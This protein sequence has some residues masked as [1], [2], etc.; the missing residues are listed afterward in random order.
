MK[1]PL[2]VTHKKQTASFR[3]VGWMLAIAPLWLAPH[4]AAPQGVP[5]S[6]SHAFGSSGSGNN[7]S[8]AIRV[9]PDQNLY[10]IGQFSSTA[11][12]GGTTITSAGGSDIFVAKYNPSGSLLLITQAGGSSD[13]IGQGIDVDENANVYVTGSFHGD[14]TFYSANPNDTKIEVVS[15]ENSEQIFLAKYNQSGT[16]Q[17][18]QTGAIFFPQFLNRGQAV[19]VNSATGTVYLAAVNQ[20]S[21]TF[22]SA[23]GKIHVVDGANEWHMVLAR[24]DTN[25]NFQWAQTN[26]ANPNSIPYAVA[27]DAQGNAYVTGWLENSTTFSSANGH[28]ITAVGFSPGQSDQNFPD[29]AF[30]AKYDKNG[31]VKWVNHIGGYKAIPSAL[32][33][34]PSGEVS[35]VGFIGNI[36]NGT[37]GEA[38]TTATSQPPGTNVSLGGGT[39]TNPYNLDEVIATYSGSGVLQRVLRRGGSGDERATGVAYDSRSNLYVTGLAEVSGHPNLF[40]DEYSSSNLLWHATATNAGIWTGQQPAIMPAMA[41]DAAGSAFVTGAYAGAAQFGDIT[42]NGTG[43]S[44]AFIA[45]LNTAFANQM[46]DLLLRPTA[47]PLPV[48]QGDLLTYTFPV[49]NLGPNVAYHEVLN[50]QVP[51]GTTFDYVRISGTPGLGTCTTPPYGGTGQIICHENGSMAPNTTW[52]VRLTVKVTAPSGTV[53]TENAATMADTPDPNMANNTATVSTTVQREA[54]KTDRGLFREDKENRRG[55]CTKSRILPVGRTEPG[56]PTSARLVPP[57]PEPDRLHLRDASAPY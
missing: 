21:V 11:D 27:V 53:I 56:T 26:A 33:I 2:C 42:L 17:W 31:N 15:V 3:I 14:T 22:S 45:R 52:T 4:A 39:F 19:A 44:E 54:A 38:V 13:D 57:R 18:V 9:G 7:F 37:P 40:V 5:P 35:I 47:S 30:L 28:P 29:D 50:T 55:A 49:W 12:F 16:L 20:G 36:N 51:A 8:N 46:A 24:Y 32:A 34:G 23:D 1:F 43:I 6:W 48:K 41:V 10:V 25:G